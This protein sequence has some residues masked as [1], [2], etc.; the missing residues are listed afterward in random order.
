MLAPLA[1]AFA[2]PVAE[3]PADNEITVLANRLRDWR[4]VWK[5]RDDRV[6]CR[7]KRSSGDKAVDAIGCSAMIDCIAPLIP[8]LKALDASDLPR[9]EAERQLSALLDSAKVFDCVEERRD[10]GLAALAAQRRSRRT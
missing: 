4:G 9:A 2:Q 6:T 5:M 8:D 7:T 3:P 10:S 1:F